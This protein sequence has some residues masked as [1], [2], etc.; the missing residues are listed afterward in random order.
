M[1]NCC[2]GSA[3]NE[4]K[5]EFYVNNSARYQEFIKE[6]SE[7][8]AYVSEL[9]H[10]IRFSE[11]N[12]AREIGIDEGRLQVQDC[13][14]GILVYVSCMNFKNHIDCLDAELT[15]TQG[16]VSL[17]GDNYDFNSYNELQKYIDLLVKYQ[18]DIQVFSKKMNEL[19]QSGVKI[20]NDLNA[21]T[22]ATT[23]IQPGPNRSIHKIKQ[24]IELV[25]DI[26]KSLNK[27]KDQI[28]RRMKQLR[29]I[30]SIVKSDSRK[31]VEYGKVAYLEGFESVSLI[32]NDFVPKIRH[33]F[34]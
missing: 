20:L 12:L 7:A 28:D 11:N 31:I 6:I 8:K 21:D 19:I 15:A 25:F 23:T 5:F 34:Q 26:S 14:L 3:K 18:R 1:G 4:L 32:M 2:E 30:M 9:Q 13:Y 24:N 33:D 27:L 10:M 17:A 16:R 29:S 22:T